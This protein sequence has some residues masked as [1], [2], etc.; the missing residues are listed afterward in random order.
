MPN[1]TLEQKL[2]KPAL[3]ANPVPDHHLVI[4]RRVGGGGLRFHSLLG[5]DDKLGLVD[6]V[7][8][9]SSVAVY[10]VTRDQNLRHNMNI[11]ALKSADHVGPFALNLTLAFRITDPQVLVEKLESDPLERLE[12]EAREVLG[13]VASRMDW[14]E[15][16]ASAHNF[17][18]HLLSTAIQDESG[19]RVPSLIFLQRFA[20]ELGLELKGIQVSR[21]L[22]A[23]VGEAA[24]VLLRERE[25]RII[26]E[27]V[28]KTALKNDQLLAQREEFQI[29]KTNTIDNIKRLGAIS[30]S[31]TNN[32]A[33]V[34]EQI[35]DKVDTAPALRTVMSELI[36]MRDEI[37]M[38]S[39]VGG[40]ASTNVVSQEMKT[41]AVSSGTVL[42][43]AAPAA[44]LTGLLDGL[45]TL[46]LKPADRN[47]LR[48]CLLHLAG[49]LA[50]QGEADPVAIDACFC[51]LA[52][53]MSLLGEVAQTADQRD[54]LI[55]F[56]D[57]DWLRAELAQR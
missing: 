52:D 1:L 24:R 37:A 14:S 23:E 11:P 53:Q 15:I 17:E 47:Q 44:G 4:F 55:R 51:N 31:A 38:I 5:P 43:G 41:L 6:K 12:R 8:L 45:A 30:A 46:P 42:L 18:D 49:E 19:R 2:V 32:L 16:Q 21:Q 7:R 54:L 27:E 29:W 35:A 34:L 10:A 13:R 26:D 28:Q 50:R 22:P 56:Q 20:E 3:D 40:G 57:Q 36:S 25:R 48:A 9:G 33:K 39:A